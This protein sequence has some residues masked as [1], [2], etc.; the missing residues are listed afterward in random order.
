MLRAP[1]APDETRLAEHYRKGR[2]LLAGDAAHIHA[3]MGGQGLNVGIQDAMNLGWKLASV[4]RG[5]ASEALLDTYER[6]RWPVGEVLRRNTLAQVALFCKFDP[7]ALAL[8]G[9][10]ED[11]L[12]V[13]EVNHQLAAEGSGFGVAYPEPLFPPNPGWEHRN[14]VSGQRLPDMDLVLADG[15]RKALYRFLEDGRWVRLQAVPDEEATS[16]AAWIK[17]INLAPGANDGLPADFASVLVRPDG[18]LAHMRPKG[19]RNGENAGDPPVLA[20]IAAS[21]DPKML[22]N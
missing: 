7:S 17:S 14:G 19:A 9:T 21:G 1:S 13:R 22:R 10:F 15:S 3:P 4:L 8:R 12:R 20:S 2:I 5:S 18:Y 6:E 16:D 11:I